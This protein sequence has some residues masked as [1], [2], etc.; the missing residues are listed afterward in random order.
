MIEEAR[1]MDSVAGK[2]QRGSWVSTDAGS[3]LRGRRKANTRPE[4]ELRRALHALGLRFRLH[5]RLA[6]GCT[7][8]LVL[9]KYRLAVFVDGCFWHGCSRHGRSTFTG[10]NAALWEDKLR[11]NKVRDSRADALATD[12][13]WEVLRLW[14]CDVLADPPATAMTVKSACTTT[15]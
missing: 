6:T 7:P 12:A 3:H 8:D 9:P 10:P 5:R 11:R 1:S 13:G 14:E 15:H 4:V 2:R